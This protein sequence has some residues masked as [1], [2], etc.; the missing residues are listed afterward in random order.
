[1]G[2]RRGGVHLEREERTKRAPENH[3]RAAEEKVMNHPS[4]PRIGERK[5]GNRRGE[6]GGERI[7]SSGKNRGAIAVAE[8]EAGL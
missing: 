6:G 1:L 4:N 3:G 5:E 2:K 7:I 8:R